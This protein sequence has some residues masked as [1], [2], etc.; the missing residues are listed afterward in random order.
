MEFVISNINWQLSGNEGI[1]WVIDSLTLESDIF[2]VVF[3]NTGSYD[4]TLI[5]SNSCAADTI[6]NVTIEEFLADI[7]VEV[8]NENLCSPDDAILFLIDDTY[9]NP[10]TTSYLISI[11]AGEDNLIGT[12]NFNQS[13][14]PDQS[15]GVLLDEINTSSCD[16]IYDDASYNGTY[17]FRLRPLIYVF[18]LQYF[19]NFI[20]LS[21][22]SSVLN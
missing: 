4:V 22:N 8:N 9:L 11:Y 19:L 12:Y 13:S 18:S 3:L 7:G 17:K 20:M 2:K 5:S 15:E 6:I 16:F 10:D 1:D 21:C 14:L